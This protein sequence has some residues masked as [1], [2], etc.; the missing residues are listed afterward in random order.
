MIRNCWYV[1]GY[2]QDFEPGTLYGH[3]IM[4]RPIVAWRTRLEKVTALDDRCAHKRYPLSKGKLL[5]DDILECGYHGFS[6]NAD[7]R[8]VGIPALHDRTE[9]IPRTAAQKK[10]PVVER[11]GYVW[12]WLGE[13]ELA[14]S[15]PPPMTPELGSTDWETRNSPPVEV[16]ANYRLLLENLFDLTHF[17]PLH[18]ETIGTRADANIPVEITRDVTPS[19]PT[20]KTARRRHNFRFGPMRRDRFGLE[21]GDQ[22]QE[23][24]MMSPG[25]VRVRIRIAP[26]GRLSTSDEQ[27]YVLYQTITPIDEGRHVWRRS[28]ACPAGSRWAGRPEV[29]LVD[30]ITAGAPKVVE[31][32]RQAVEEQWKM[33]RHP[34]EG[35]REVHVK[36]DGPV[37]ILRRMLDEM[38][39]QERNLLPVPVGKAQLDPLRSQSARRG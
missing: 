25:L 28:T 38:E 5:P 30:A 26:P 17:Y 18:A 8:C 36:T 15:T 24:E 4:G 9:N 37:I 3:I 22:I 23:H 6:Y 1:L 21:Y 12:I 10:Y 39:D 20:L 33:Y 31:E 19:G 13:E 16:A 2:S 27:N 35:Y 29:A 11:D 14:S 34:D 7:G 32:D